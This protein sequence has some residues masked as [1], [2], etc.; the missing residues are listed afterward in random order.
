[1]LALQTRLAGH[2]IDCTALP[3]RP[4]PL[5]GVIWRRAPVWPALHHIGRS[6]AGPNVECRQVVVAMNTIALTLTT[7]QDPNQQPM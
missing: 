7:V 6:N 5:A 3:M 2:V 4:S 1:M